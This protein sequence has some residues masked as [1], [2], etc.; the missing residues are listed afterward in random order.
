MEQIHE[1]AQIRGM[2]W[3]NTDMNERVQYDECDQAGM[4]VESRQCRATNN[5]TDKLATK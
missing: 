1:M 3:L 5:E 2:E 4:R